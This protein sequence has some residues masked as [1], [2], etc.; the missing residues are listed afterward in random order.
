MQRRRKI[1]VANDRVI[2]TH[3][4]RRRGI[5][6]ANDQ[7]YNSPILIRRHYDVNSDRKKLNWLIANKID[8]IKTV[9]KPKVG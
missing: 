1:D 4:Q 8:V 6:V 9:T 5:D 7:G 3:I 2:T